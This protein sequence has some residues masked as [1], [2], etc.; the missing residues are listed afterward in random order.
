MKK[1][2]VVFVNCI[3]YKQYGG[4]VTARSQEEAKIGAKEIIFREQPLYSA[5]L[6]MLWCHEILY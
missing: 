1:Y 3:N 4:I 2:H 5:H 6:K